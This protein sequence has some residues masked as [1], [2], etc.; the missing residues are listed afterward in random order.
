MPCTY[1]VIIIFDINTLSKI[2]KWPIVSRKL[3]DEKEWSS[4]INCNEYNSDRLNVNKHMNQVRN[5]NILKMAYCTTK[6]R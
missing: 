1:T 5:F 3:H 2:M 4:T 6:G